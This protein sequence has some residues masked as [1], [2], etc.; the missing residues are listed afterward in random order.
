MGHRYPPAFEN[1][2]V[3]LARVLLTLLF[4]LVGWGKL[5][6]PQGTIETMQ[7]LGAPVPTV[8]A[9]IAIIMEV[10][11]AL[12]ILLGYMTRPLALL[13][14]LYTLGTAF[15]GHA[16]WL[17]PDAQQYGN[18]LHFYKNLGIAGGLLLLAKTG[19]GGYALDHWQDKRKTA[20]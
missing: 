8:S 4:I 15:I 10:P 11:V 2:S 14:A 5:M 3:L 12:A 7:R 18:M 13:L 17:M 9:I 6:D 16:Y 20:T 1:V 19:P